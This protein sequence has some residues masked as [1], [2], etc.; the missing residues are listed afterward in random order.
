MKAG[1]MPLNSDR[2]GLML[3]QF[4]LFVNSNLHQVLPFSQ[5]VPLVA[6]EHLNHHPRLHR[7]KS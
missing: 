1:L 5:L 6:L 2:L 3:P 4:E 7:L